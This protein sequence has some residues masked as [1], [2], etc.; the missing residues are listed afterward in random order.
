VS[1]QPIDLNAALGEAYEYRERI[2]VPDSYYPVTVRVLSTGLS[3]AKMVDVKGDDGKPVIDPN[4][5]QT[6][7]EEGGNAPFV[8]LETSIYDGPFKGMTISR[9]AHIVPGKKGGAL[10]R[11]LGAANAITRSQAQVGAVALKFGIPLPAVTP[12]VVGK[13]TPEQAA[14]RAVRQAIA[15]GFYALDPQT[16]LGFITT[17]LMVPAWDGKKAI[18][19]L[20]FEER[21]VVGNDGITR[22]YS[23]ND[24]AGFLPLDHKEHGYDFVKRVEFPTQYDVFKIMYPDTVCPWTP[25]TSG[26]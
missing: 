17:L 23:N 11:W 25:P 7:Q 10:G 1:G 14:Q 12:P 20:T 9:K 24:F 22:K 26:A 6:M 13:E 4:T 15:E 19:K 18:A 5:G 21:D 3:A 8:E 16:R 2:V